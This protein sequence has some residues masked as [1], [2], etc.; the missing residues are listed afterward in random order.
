VTAQT[1]AAPPGG[2]SPAQIA[3]LLALVKA[4]AA[5]RKQ[6]TD[7][8]S[9]AALAAM[10]GFTAWWDADAVTQMIADV[11][12]VVQPLQRQ[13]A[14]I[15]DGYLTRAATIISGRPQRAT[16]AVDVQ[17]L[18][19]AMTEELA[20]QILAGVRQAARVELGGLSDHASRDVQESPDWGLEDGREALDPAMVYG[21]VADGY[22][23][24][25]TMLG[26]SPDKAQ[27]K[28]AVRIAAVAET[29]VTLA[30]RAQYQKT[31]SAQGATG[32]RRILHPELSQTG[33]CA[34][35]VVAADRVYRTEDLL[36]LHSRCVP[37]GTR[38][39]AEGVRTLTRRRYS[40]TLV[41]LRTASGQELTITANHPVLTDRGW[42]PAHLV[43]EGDHVVRHR[44][45]HGVVGRSPHEDDVPPTVE[46]VWRAAVMAGAPARSGVPVAAEDFHGDWSNSE[47]HA[48]STD[49]L[50]PRVGDVSFSE[51]VR[52]AA[53]VVGHRRGSRLAGSGAPLVSFFR[54][55]PP[56]AAGVGAL[57]LGLPLCRRHVRVV[58]AKRGGLAT[59]RNTRFFEAEPD[60]S[61][62]NAVLMRQGELSRS[63]LVRGD[64]RGIRKN[65]SYASRLDASGLEFAAQ[66][67]NTDAKFS[68]D[69]LRR[70]AGLVKGNRPVDK[71]RVESFMPDLDAALFELLA[72]GH[73]AEA[74]LGGDLSRGPTG[75]VQDNDPVDH[76]RRDR[77]TRPTRFDPAGF[78][79]VA[80]GRVAYAQ[81]GGDLLR[82]LAGQVELDRVVEYRRIEGTH[83]VFNLHTNEGW[84]SANGVIVSNCVCEVLP[85]YQGADPGLTLNGD[86]LAAIYAAAGGNTREQLRRASVVLTEH[87][88]LGPVL[89]HGDQHY[90][91]PQE[92]ARNYASSRRVRE[93]AI[94]ADL[95]QRFDTTKLRVERGDPLERTLRSQQTRIAE[96]KQSLGVG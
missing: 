40:G 18:R 28:A 73:H 65:L 62:F 68:G 51:P 19:R 8:A 48:V 31:M 5:V 69:V 96:L 30:V 12:R 27:A 74:Q 87:G 78:E 66:R 95:E 17:A 91:S 76:F 60:H 37:A 57:D 20:D 25:T 54:D 70:S 83:E 24:Q 10:A 29:D 2:L 7:A 46:E 9:A 94:L 55:G 35:C 52:E 49:G 6:L 39:A 64:D 77:R 93:R 43:G 86:D 3:A 23:W 81:L 1:Q 50:L 38:V 14:T 4:Q 34:L 11:L 75:L 82:R 47:V 80:D 16:G 59:D 58:E 26:D 88:E 44:A 53:L 72:D 84:Y 56:T 13:A 15:T 61:A 85:V 33:P 21:R 92:V 36:P 71:A 63:S 79:F 42:V 32:W 22:R 67:G 45:G 41:I 89:V 90:R